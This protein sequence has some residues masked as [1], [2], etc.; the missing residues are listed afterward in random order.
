MIG[1][2]NVAWHLARQFKRSGHNILQVFSRTKAEAEFLAAETQAAFTENIEEIDQQGSL[3]VIAVNDDAVEEV[4]EQLQFPNG[5]VVH[6]S[7]IVAMEALEPVSENIGVFYPLQTMT[8]GHDLDFRGIPVF[9]EASDKAT[10]DALMTLAHQISD[11]VFEAN[12]QKRKTLHIAAIFANNFT[13]H[14]YHISNTLL[15]REEMNLGILLPLI[16]ETTNKLKANNPFDVQTGPAKRG[17]M[18]TIEEHLDLLNEF[19]EFR[20]IYLVLT[21]SLIASYRE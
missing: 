6:T 16:Q 10:S 21:E 11:K 2:G 4:A 20:E 7:A 18:K 14:L 12:L 13:N 9:I 5:M 1:A 3:Y 8:K 15:K 17:D 19:P